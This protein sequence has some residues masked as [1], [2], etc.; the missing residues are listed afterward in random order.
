MIKLT[1]GVKPAYLT[2][3]VVED[4]TNQ[5]LETGKSVWNRAAIKD[6][7]LESSSSKCAY[8]EADVSEESKYMEVEHFRFKDSFPDLVVVWDNL[9]PSCKRC[10]GRKGTYNV[11][12]DGEIVNPYDTLPSAHMY[13]QNYRLRWRDEMGRRTI[14]DALYLN[15]SERLVSVRMKLGEGVCSALETIR[16]D[17]ESYQQ[18]DVTVRKWAKIVR[19]VEKL[20]KEAQPESPF[21]A[22]TATALLTDPDYLWIR[23]E[24][25][26]FPDW[27][28]LEL[29]ETTAQN[30]VLVQ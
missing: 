2:D 22:L 28:D 23:G 5:Y 17:L 9:L 1:R 16:S 21:S 13:F 19:G 4:L 6:P 11:D 25:S 14:I 24:L 7:L 29:L 8:C 18:G 10:N 20:L 12:V 27:Q 26:A 15:D 30:L 3:A